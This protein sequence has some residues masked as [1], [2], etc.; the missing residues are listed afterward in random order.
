MIRAVSDVWSL[1]E[2]DG[3][4]EIGRFRIEAGRFI[5]GFTNTEARTWLYSVYAWVGLADDGLVL[6]IGKAEGRLEKRIAAYKRSL[7][8]AMSDRLGPGEFFL[9]DT[10]PWEREGWIAYASAPPGGLLYARQI[11]SPT[12]ADADTA[13]TLEQLER[14]LIRRYDP[15]L[16]GVS[17]AGRSR[18]KAWVA[19]RGIAV[20]V[21]KRRVSGSPEPH[22]RL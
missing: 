7:D 5:Y 14:G 19:E 2:V 22:G 16:C 3:F 11:A 18:K 17:P 9:G 21:S 15:P 12:G 6:R 1:L 4:V 20:A 8:D 10:Q 13:A